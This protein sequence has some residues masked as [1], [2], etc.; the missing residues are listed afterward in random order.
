MENLCWAA[1]I[2]GAVMRRGCAGLRRIIPRHE[3]WR[4]RSTRCCAPMFRRERLLRISS[5]PMRE[6]DDDIERRSY[7]ANDQNN[8]RAR[9]EDSSRK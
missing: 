9:E 6:D 4:A 1:A 3:S 2:R 5:P 8:P 7:L